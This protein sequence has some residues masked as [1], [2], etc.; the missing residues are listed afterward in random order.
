MSV[1]D[2]RVI[3]FLN[4]DKICIKDEKSIS[5]NRKLAEKLIFEIN[6]VSYFH[7]PFITDYFIVLNRT[8]YI[9][10]INIYIYIYIFIYKCTYV[11]IYIYINIY[12]YIIFYIYIFI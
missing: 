10:Y 4:V 3:I 12:I 7:F 5:I 1:L 6:D 8:I 9:S 2:V 11:F